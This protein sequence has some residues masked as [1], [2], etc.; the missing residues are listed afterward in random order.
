M[1][2]MSSRCIGDQDRDRETGMMRRTCM[3]TTLLTLFIRS[4]MNEQSVAINNK[5]VKPRGGRDDV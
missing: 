1:V 5:H 3:H 4:D 2:I